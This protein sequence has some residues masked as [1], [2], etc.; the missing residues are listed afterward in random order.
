MIFAI[1]QKYLMGSI[2]P[3]IAPGVNPA[4]ARGNTT[5]YILQ[6]SVVMGIA[7]SITS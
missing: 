1:G 3:L 7:G 2:L 6:E 4:P 5:Y